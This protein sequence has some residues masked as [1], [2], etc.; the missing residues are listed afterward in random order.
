MEAG[1]VTG[2]VNDTEDSDV[3]LLIVNDDGET[4]DDGTDTDANLSISDMVLRDGTT[5]NPALETGTEVNSSISEAT[6]SLQLSAESSGVHGM[7]GNVTQDAVVVTRNDVNCPR[8]R[9]RSHRHHR[10]VHCTP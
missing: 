1:S 9:R 2:I 10:S 6:G 5:S 8:H 7:S 3:S 4:V